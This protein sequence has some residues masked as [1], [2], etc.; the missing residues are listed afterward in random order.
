MALLV[1][2]QLH[3]SGAEP[4][5]CEASLRA[6]SFGLLPLTAPRTEYNPQGSVVILFTVNADGTVSDVSFS[7]WNILPADGFMRDYLSKSVKA[8]RFPVRECAC[9]GQQ[10]TT[11]ALNEDA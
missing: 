3:G 9:S 6:E 1:G 11:I 10:R 7:D 2:V 8:W 4:P 5:K